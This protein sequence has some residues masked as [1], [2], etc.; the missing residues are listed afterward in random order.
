VSI[1]DQGPARILTPPAAVIASTL[2]EWSPQFS[3]DGK[4]MVFASDRT[5]NWEI[6]VASSD[7]TKQ[8]QLTTFR[9]S[10]FTG[11]ARW[12]PDGQR[13]VFESITGGH[14]DI[15]VIGAD[16]GPAERLTA[17][18]FDGSRPSWSQ[19][20]RWIYFRSDRSGSQQI[21]K[22]AAAKP[23]KPVVQVTRNGGWDAAEALDGKLLYFTKPATRGLWSIPVNGGDESRLLD[24]V[25]RGYWS[26]AENGIYFVEGTG[27]ATAKV[28][29]YSFG[30][31]KLTQILKIEKP[32]FHVAP[33]FSTTRDGR[34][35]AWDQADREQ[36]DLMLLENF[37]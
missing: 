3:P 20:G 25:F 23:Y 24:P 4:R 13:I 30:S 27:F 7:G 9:Q 1:P 22:M 33:G 14:G 31:R 17:D 2:N 32:I 6:W 11:C 8:V 19:D 28:Q 18:R 5:G 36:S 16:G 10:A 12:S 37:R 21:W 34:W 29:F 35:I 15:Y 26:V